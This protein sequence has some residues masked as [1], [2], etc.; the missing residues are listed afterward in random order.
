MVSGRRKRNSINFIHHLLPLPSLPDELVPGLFTTPTF[1]QFIIPRLR[2]IFTVHDT[3]IRMILL[4]HFHKF[5]S[6]F[7][8]HELSGCVLPQLLL[9][10]KDTNDHLVAMTL[11]CLA[12]LVPILGA[13]IVIGKNRNRIFADGRPQRV[14]ADHNPLTR[15]W[16]EARSITPVMME[17]SSSEVELCQQSFADVSA[18]HLMPV[19]LAPDGGEDVGEGV[20]RVMD[21]GAGGVVGVIGEVGEEDQWSDWD[22]EEEESHATAV[23]SSSLIVEESV[24]VRPPTEVAAQ[25]NHS[26][27]DNL[28]EL[29][30]QVKVARETD[31]MD[32]FKDME[33]VIVKREVDLFAAAAAEKEAQGPTED[34]LR[35]E[36][37][38][39]RLTI[40]VATAAE[41]DA[42][43]GQGGWG[44]SDWE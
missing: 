22:N 1:S 10:I 37:A 39:S 21:G 43:E 16:P 2:Q 44:D 34:S 40:Q 41:G 5:M 17:V 25:R 31:E 3:Q 26:V 11:R 19:R 14:A 12:D 33:P 23:V 28:N 13:S 35:G 24:I 15:H 20:Q 32:F 30:I 18:E 6:L 8:E 29:D 36:G 42:E 27:A 4:E 7:P 9:G 38:K